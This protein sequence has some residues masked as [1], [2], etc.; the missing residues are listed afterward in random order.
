MTFPDILLAA[1][2]LWA[3]SIIIR[4]GLSLERQAEAAYRRPYEKGG[5]RGH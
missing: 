5:R 2:G 4:R 3:L 1:G